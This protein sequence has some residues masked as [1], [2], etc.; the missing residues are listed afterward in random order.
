M[1]SLV[2]SGLRGGVGTT[3][4]LAGIGFALHAQG[5]RV[6]LVDLCPDNQLRLHFNLAVGETQ[7]WA[8]AQTEGQAWNHAAFAIDEH[9]HLLPYGVL[10]EVQYF[11]LDD[12]L[13][14]HPD[15]WHTRCA[16]LAEPYDWILFDVPQCLPGH[17]RLLGGGAPRQ[18]T[19]L[20]LEAD[21]ACHARLAGGS[22]PRADLLLVNRFDPVSQ[23]QRD[24]LLLWREKYGESRLHQVIH[25]DEAVQ[26][27]L[28]SKSPVGFHAPHSQAASEMLSLATWCQVRGGSL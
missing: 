4:L 17:R 7:G 6:L 9:L 22:P 11:T 24:L 13:Y 19:V 5:K 10:D 23:L 27:S 1:N 20:A 2:M 15:C 18:V 12:W 26:E 14:R 16:A 8:R 28:A 3:S 21:A 25:R